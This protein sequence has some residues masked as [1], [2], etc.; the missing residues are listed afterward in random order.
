MEVYSHAVSCSEHCGLV[1]TPLEGVAEVT[2]DAG[3]LEG[4]QGQVVEVKS[5]LVCPR[6][7][8][9]LLRVAL[10]SNRLWQKGN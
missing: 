9:V 4:D 3:V 8:E 6:H 7:H 1:W 5:S 10:V 2:P